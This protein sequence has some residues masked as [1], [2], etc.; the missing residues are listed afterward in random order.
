V[1]HIF[2]GLSELRVAAV[3]H[4]TAMIVA[5]VG[6]SVLAWRLRRVRV[7]REDPAEAAAG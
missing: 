2:G 1:S 5:A 7:P 6:G 3:G 4:A